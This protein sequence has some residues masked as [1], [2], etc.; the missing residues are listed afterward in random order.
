MLHVH[1]SVFFHLHV[2]QFF[3]I[4][5]YLRTLLLLFLVCFQAIL[6]VCLTTKT[7]PSANNKKR[8]SHYFIQDAPMKFIIPFV[9]LCTEM[10]VRTQGQSAKHRFYMLVHVHIMLF[11][12]ELQY[13]YMYR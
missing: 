9:E 2:H 13:M 7:V 4:Y 12:V 1:A 6:E 10:I 8:S 3:H 11:V 5:N